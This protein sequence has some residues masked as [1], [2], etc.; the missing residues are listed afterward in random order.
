MDLAEQLCSIVLLLVVMIIALYIWEE[1]VRPLVRK[2]TFLG[3]LSP[4]NQTC[5]YGYYKNPENLCNYC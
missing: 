4:D 2:D 3:R 5:M 1:Y